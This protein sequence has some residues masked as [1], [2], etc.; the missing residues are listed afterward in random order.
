MIQ[1][2]ISDL[3]NDDKSLVSS[4]L[5]TKVFASRIKNKNLLEW[6]NREINGYSMDDSLPDYRVGSAT[7][8]CT[9]RQGYAMQENTPVPISFISDENLRNFFVQF[10]FRDSVKTLESYI[11]NKENDTL[12]KILPIDFW[13]LLTR[14]MKENGFKSEIRDIRS[15][16]LFNTPKSTL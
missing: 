2:I 5:K 16:Q 1:Q 7:S 4:L 11:N 9:L 6:V 8:S 13:A 14:H 10:E 15:Y 12:M 3:T